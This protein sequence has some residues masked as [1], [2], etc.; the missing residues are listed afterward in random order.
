MQKFGLRRLW[1]ECVSPPLRQR[2]QERYMRPEFI[3]DDAV[4]E[5]KREQQFARWS[6]YY[7]EADPSAGC[8]PALR[9]RG[10]AAAL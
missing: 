1:F 7:A 8:G 9:A 2:V 6:G 4:Y 5:R 10:S 3:E